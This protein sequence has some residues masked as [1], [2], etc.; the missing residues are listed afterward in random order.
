MTLRIKEKN[1]KSRFPFIILKIQKKILK[2]ATKSTKNIKMCNFH[3]ESIPTAKSRRCRRSPWRT[4]IPPEICR[5]WSR[6]L[7]L[8]SRKISVMGIILG[9]WEGKLN[10]IW[11]FGKEIFEKW[12][13]FWIFK[14]KSEIWKNRIWGVVGLRIWLWESG[15]CSGLRISKS[16]ICRVKD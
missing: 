6:V 3:Q 15:K 12:W 1:P 2:N 9:L 10:G 14:E 11:D 16:E 7:R 4:G 8:G 5:R 13:M